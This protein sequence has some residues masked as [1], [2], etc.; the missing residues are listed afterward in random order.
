MW[1]VIKSLRPILWLFLIFS[2]SIIVTIDF[3]LIKI[4]EI[5]SFGNISGKI[6]REISIS[7]ISSFIFYYIV[8]HLKEQKD[9][10]ITHK[11]IANQV[12]VIIF[13]GN[14]II[15]DSKNKN[16]LR[17]HVN[18]ISTTIDRI[19]IL[20]QSIDP[21]LTIILS[22]ISGSSLFH[23]QTLTNENGIF[24]KSDEEQIYELIETI[25]SLQSYYDNELRKYN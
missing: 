4:P 21:N 1:E 16:I 24:I 20:S 7:Y 23:N 11:Y 17:Y 2:V 12:F 10:K 18:L 22:K 25:Q 6:L 9:K 8:V 5:W 19:L 15:T 3:W 13:N 14:Q